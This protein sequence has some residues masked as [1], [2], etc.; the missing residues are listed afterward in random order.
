MYVEGTRGGK[1]EQT[2]PCSRPV[3]S[4]THLQPSKR[5]ICVFFGVSF[6]IFGWLFVGIKT[7]D[8]LTGAYALH[9]PRHNGDTY[10]VTRYLNDGH[11]LDFKFPF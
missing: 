1:L 7:W 6:R 4:L 2:W 11:L 3:R 10:Q 8:Q 5:Q 9:A